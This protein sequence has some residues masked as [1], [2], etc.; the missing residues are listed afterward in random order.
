MKQANLKVRNQMN[1]LDVLANEYQNS[2]SRFQISAKDRQKRIDK[3][4]ELKKQAQGA[5]AAYESYINNKS[6]MAVDEEQPMI[7]NKGQDG[8]YDHT[9]DLTSEQILQQQ[10]N[11]M[12]N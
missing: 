2:G 5:M 12:L 7:R 11:Q 4:S 8:E 9:R 1:D 3:I 6:A 10:R